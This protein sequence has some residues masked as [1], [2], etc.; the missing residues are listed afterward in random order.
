MTFTHM[1]NLKKLIYFESLRWEHFGRDLPPGRTSRVFTNQKMIWHGF[2]DKMVSTQF[3]D[4]IKSYLFIAGTC[5][6]LT[7]L[8][9][10]KFTISHE[11][12]T[13][14]VKEWIRQQNLIIGNVTWKN[15]RAFYYNP[16]VPN[17]DSIR[18]SSFLDGIV[19]DTM[20]VMVKIQG[21]RLKDRRSL[22]RL[23]RLCPNLPP[24]SCL[25]NYPHWLK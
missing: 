18:R 9:E 11:L 17:N 25:S 21:L 15:A 4:N 19:N 5:A 23:S 22:S 10:N 1:N 12:P 3:P 16:Y 7:I 13:G 8:S 14:W 6:S 24:E 20:V 2:G